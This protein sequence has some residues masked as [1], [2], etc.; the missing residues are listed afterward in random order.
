[1]SSNLDPD[2]FLPLPHLPY[3]I[4]LAMATSDPLH[5]W[6]VIKRIREITGGDAPPSTGSLY[7]AISRLAERGLVEETAPPTD[8]GD[9][10]RRYYR[11]TPLGRRV[12]EAESERLAG[13]VEVARTSNVL[14][15]AK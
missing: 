10:R 2:R 15:R 4:L 1:V 7:L 14:S 11:L 6:G 9:A 13:L 5:G 12:L 3:H 8:D